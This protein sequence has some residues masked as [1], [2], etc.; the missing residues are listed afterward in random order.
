MSSCSGVA[1]LRTVVHLLLTY[2]HPF[3]GP[4][5][6]TTRV[7]QYQK[8]KPIRILLK[9]E[10]VSGSGISSAICKMPFLPPNQ[11]RQNTEGKIDRQYST[12]QMSTEVL[13]TKNDVKEIS[14]ECSL[15]HAGTTASATAKHG[16]GE[17]RKEKGK[18]K[19]HSHNRLTAFCPGLP[20]YACTR[21]NIHP[22]TPI[23]IIGH[24]L[25]SSSIYYDP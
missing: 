15:M 21:R 10:T 16:K 17:E 14:F 18:K 8:G 12:L 3:N 25:S 24:P 5:S 11:Q 20:G 1:T 23:L 9:Q 13:R 2:T 22:L 19:T 6:G 4:F 7:S